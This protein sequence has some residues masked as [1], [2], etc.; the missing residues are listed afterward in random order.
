M[1]LVQDLL[2]EQKKSYGLQLEAVDQR[3][4]RRDHPTRRARPPWPYLERVPRIRPSAG[5]QA[6][7]SVSL[8]SGLRKEWLNDFLEIRALAPRTLRLFCV[9]FFDG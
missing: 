9:V 4:V 3:Q 2:A 8:A 1:L 7:I 5:P 6:S